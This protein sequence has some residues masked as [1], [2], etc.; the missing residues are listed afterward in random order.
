[1]AERAAFLFYSQDFLIGTLTLPMEDRGKYIT[2]LCC[3]HEHGRMTE[4]AVRSLVGD[5]SEKLRAKFKIDKQGLWFNQRL[6]KEIGGRQRFV[7]SRKNNGG[8]GGR[9]QKVRHCEE[10]SNLNDNKGDCHAPLAVTVGAQAL[11]TGGDKGGAFIPP[12]PENVKERFIICGLTAIEAEY[13][14]LKFMAYYTGAGWKTNRGH[15]ITNWKAAVTNWH[16]RSKQ[17]TKHKQHKT[18]TELWLE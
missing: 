17:F 4:E 18:L 16:V 11:T 2:L 9:P 14:T 6:E 8:R 10:R 12:L 3:M 13:E 15:A 7:K 1:M 5:I